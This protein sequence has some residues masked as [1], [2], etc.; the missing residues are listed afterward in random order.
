MAQ[1]LLKALSPDQLWNRKD[2]IIPMIFRGE[3]EDE[4]SRTRNTMKTEDLYRHYKGQLEKRN[5]I[6][7]PGE[8][9]LH[10]ILT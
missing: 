7:H 4:R 8:S 9:T 10:S 3:I 2:K 1:A 6:D 5:R